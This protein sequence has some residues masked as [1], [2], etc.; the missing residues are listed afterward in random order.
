VSPFA[1][2]AVGLVD[3]AIRHTNILSDNISE[4][5]DK[6]ISIECKTKQ[7]ESIL[8]KAMAG[9]FGACYCFRKS[10]FNEIPTGRMIADD[11]YINMQALTKGYQTLFNTDAIV[12]EDSNSNS[13]AEYKRRVRIASGCWTNFAI[14]FPSIINPFTKRG[15]IMLSHKVLRWFVPFFLILIAVELVILAPLYTSIAVGLVIFAC[16]ISRKIR[17]YFYYFISSNI[18]IIHGLYQVLF[19]TKTTIW[20]PTPRK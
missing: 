5:E 12:L 6:Y 3:A 8:F 10:A 11:F 16:G 15:F 1:N 7:A 20:T 19:S 9:P 2:P 17:R 13:K 4:Q 14:F 18:A